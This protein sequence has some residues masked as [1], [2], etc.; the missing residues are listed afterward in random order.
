[1]TAR[2]GGSAQKGPLLFPCHACLAW[3][4]ERRAGVSRAGGS[5]RAGGDAYEVIAWARPGP[6]PPPLHPI[7]L[8]SPTPSP[9]A[10]HFLLKL[11]DS[12]HAFLVPQRLPVSWC[13]LFPCLPSPTPLPFPLTQPSSAPSQL[14]RTVSLLLLFISL[15]SLPLLDPR[16]TLNP[17]SGLSKTLG[18]WLSRKS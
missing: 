17:A 8:L 5:G 13:L 2:P 1:M 12:A 14:L 15:C 16:S 18:H 4:L 10:Q 7:D 6:L 3:T 9:E 11:P